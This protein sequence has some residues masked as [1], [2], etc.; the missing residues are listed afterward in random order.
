MSIDRNDYTSTPLTVSE[1]GL[2]W[3]HVAI[4]E[5]WERPHIEAYVRRVLEEHRPESVLEIGYGLGYTARAIAD[6]GIAR[7]IIVEC[8]PDVI[9]N[10]RQWAGDKPRVEILY[11]FVEDIEL[12]T[13]VDLIWDD[14]HALTDYGDDWI[15]R[16][17]AAHYIKFDV[18]DMMEMTPEEYRQFQLGGA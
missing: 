7:H 4:M 15:A 2:F 18:L 16:V 9:A 14:R 6:F 17:G 12:P 11:G 3:R 1:R 13:G 10:A 8:H 5:A